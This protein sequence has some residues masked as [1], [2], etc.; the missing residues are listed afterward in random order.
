M[1]LKIDHINRA[2]YELRISGLTVTPSPENNRAA[3]VLLEDMFAELEETY[4]ICV[5]YNFEENPDLNSESGISRGTNNMAGTNLAIALAA[6]FNKPVNPS[7]DNL[8]GRAMSGVTAKVASDRA[9][10]VLPSARMPVG[11]G[12][13]Y[14]NRHRQF[15]RPEVLAPNTC[16]TNRMVIDDVNTFTESFHSYLVGET[17]ASFTIEASAG[18]TVL[19]SS[20]N[21]DVVTYRVQANQPSGVGSF[22][23]LIIVITTSTG[24]VKSRDIDFEISG[25]G[26]PIV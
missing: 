4:D 20:N 15:E 9:R 22:N 17:I 6:S 3:L 16:S 12:Y 23:K 10:Q 13:R 18:L 21:D 1:S 5:G 11:S 25:N 8:A 2:Y 19:T 7:L 26:L 24:R 14:R